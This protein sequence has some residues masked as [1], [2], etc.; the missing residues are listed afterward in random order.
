MP[1]E[2]V[3]VAFPSQPLQA[4]SCVRK[5]HPTSS[6]YVQW[7]LKE[8]VTSH[9]VCQPTWLSKTNQC[10][11]KMQEGLTVDFKWLQLCL[12]RFRRLWPLNERQQPLCQTSMWKLRFLASLCRPCHAFERIIQLVVTTCNGCWKKKSHHIGF[13]NRLGFPKQIRALTKCRKDWQ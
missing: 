13:V 11:H 7:L 6:N 5:D 1:D 9:R 4:M 10:P 2:P 12:V 8:E 3:E